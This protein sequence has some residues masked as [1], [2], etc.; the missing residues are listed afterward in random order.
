[1]NYF[2]NLAQKYLSHDNDRS[3]PLPEAQLFWRLEELEERRKE[4]VRA[5]APSESWTR[6]TE[7]EFRFASPDCFKS[8]IDV[9]KAIE[10]AIS[11]L[12]DNYG[13][14][15]GAVNETNTPASKSVPENQ[16]SLFDVITF[17]TTPD[18]IVAA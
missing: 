4:L 2:T 11:E 12:K 10:L 17:P 1:M 7:D 15:I 8:I 6:F 3:F 5:D 14:D 9:K 16:I 13:I 18:P